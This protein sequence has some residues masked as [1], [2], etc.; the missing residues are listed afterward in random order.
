LATGI[1][2][3]VFAWL[4][5]F[6]VGSIGGFYNKMKVFE[7]WFRRIVAILFLGVGLYYVIM[8]VF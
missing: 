7:T 2:V 3:I 1:P 4:I 8:L 6:S 5:A